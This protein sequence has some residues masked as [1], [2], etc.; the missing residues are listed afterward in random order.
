MNGIEIIRYNPILQKAFRFIIENNKSNNA[1]YHNINHL[2]T[3]L[4]FV[5][6]IANGEEVYYDQR[7]PLHLAALFHDVNHSGGKLKDSENIENAIT[8]FMVF[9]G[10]N[11]GDHGLV[12]EVIKLISVT[13]FPYVKPNSNINKFDMIIRDAD[14]MQQFEYNWISQTTLGLAEESNVGIKEFIKKQR[15]FLESII[16]LTNTAKEFKKDNWKRIMNEF[17]IL[18]V[19]LEIE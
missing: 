2:L 1:P 16:F 11:L 4:K 5:D 6:Y 14:M 3:V 8:A 13:E 10:K 7:L 19:A 9:A 12:H 18:E 15:H 17:R